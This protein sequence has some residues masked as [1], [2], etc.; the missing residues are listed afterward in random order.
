MSQ[1]TL[2]G[3]LGCNMCRALKQ[4]LTCKHIDFKYVDIREDKEAA[5]KLIDKGFSTLPVLS[6]DDTY[7]TDQSLHK[8]IE[9][10]RGV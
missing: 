7:Y 6:R 9:F 2:Y 10:A 1:L 3:T 4:P 8:L 5:Q